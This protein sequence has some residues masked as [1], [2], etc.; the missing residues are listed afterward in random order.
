MKRQLR[1][2]LIVSIMAS[3][4]A[5]LD[6]S[7]VNVA[8]PAIASNLG[9]GLAVQQ[10]VVDA[11]LITLGSLILLAGSL[12]DIFGR[13]RVLTYGLIGFGAA[14]ILCAI[15]PS[16]TFLIVAR[17]L[18]GLAG[19][20]LVPSSLAIIIS[21]F[22]GKAQ[23]K[24]IGQWTAWTGISFII[25]PLLGGFLVD[26]L[27]WRYIFAI[28]IIPIAVCLYLI[29]RLELKDKISKTKLDTGGAVLCSL[30]LFGVVFALIEQ[31]YFGWSSVV[32]LAPLILGLIALV[33]FVF[34]ESKISN[35]MLPL[36]LFKV[37]N[38]SAGNIATISIYG[39]LSI[40]TFL[41]VIFLQQVGGFSA[42]N[43]GLALM[44][45]TLVM[46]FLSSQFGKLAGKY[47]PRLFMTFGPIVAGV[48]FLLM[49]SMNTHVNYLTEL[50]PGILLFAL[51]LSMTVA[52]LT[53][54]VLGD[55]DTRHS[56]IASA[57]NNA[58]ARIAGLI[59]IAIVGV[60]VGSKIDLIGFQKA[61]IIT[62]ILMFAGG[63]ISFVGIRNNLQKEVVK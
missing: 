8:L 22:S 17:G 33:A 11:Y 62:A 48:G 50:L 16:S 39:G 19:A 25:G 53:S 34:Y 60:I 29:S 49:L 52:P 46:F 47:G 23:G 12:S 28:N 61:I 15:S 10:W 43:A 24:A 6:G 2:V 40:A 45:V 9:G 13:K 1:L 38:F 4:V 3:F 58:V 51:G 41:I 18:Q 5:F 27:S 21:S 54:A 37:R 7:V 32:I 31:P 35:A 63:I 59:T 56:G 44:P 36:S 26:T 14:S 55:I 20:L 57:V 30:G 42:L